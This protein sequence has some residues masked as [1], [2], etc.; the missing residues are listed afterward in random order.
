M[1]VYDDRPAA[2]LLRRHEELTYP[3]VVGF[4]GATL[5]IDEGVFCPTL[6]RTSPFLL[7]VVEVL[8][9]ERVLDVFAGSGAFGV[10]AALRGADVVAV[11]VSPA[12][13]G[14]AR[15]NAAANGVADRLDARVG[16]V[17]DVHGV[18]DGRSGGT[19]APWLHPDEQFDVVVAN[20]PLLP[21]HATTPLEAAIL[22]P[23]L[24][25]TTAF[26]GALGGFLA[27]HGR[28]YLLTSD[29]LD[30][31]GLDI[32]ALGA[33]AGIDVRQVAAH[34]AG[35]ETYRVHVLAH[36]GRSG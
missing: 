34:D 2:A 1:T 7:T 31:V 17:R 9:G 24:S 33:A 5:T 4:G 30:R 35:Y 21:G 8:P 6:T 19:P 11:D 12:A 27:P 22:D 29:V 20:P 3:H 26:V 14:C 32:E 23:D 18:R 28:A 13:V 36:A 25:A 16:D 15:R 10:V